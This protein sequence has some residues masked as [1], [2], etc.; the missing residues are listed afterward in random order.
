MRKF[1]A[2][3]EKLSGTPDYIIASRS[4]LGKNVL[5]LP[6]VLVVEAKQNDFTKGWG[7]CL[8][9]LVAAQKLNEQ[10]SKSV[11]GI[12]T[13]GELWQFG[14]VQSMWVRTELDRNLDHNMQRIRHQLENLPESDYVPAMECKGA[15]ISEMFFPL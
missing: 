9:E 7:Q 13:D 3:D 14:Y 12:V 4:E 6:L 11:Y 15:R 5:G 1:L 8:A 10:P 2:V